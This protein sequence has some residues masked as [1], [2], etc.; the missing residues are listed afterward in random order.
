MRPLLPVLQC[1]SILTHKIFGRELKEG[2]QSSISNFK[3]EY[4]KMQ[5]ALKEIAIEQIMTEDLAS[6]AT[7]D[8]EIGHS[9]QHVMEITKPTPKIHFLLNRLKNT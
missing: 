2:W 6:M 1:D 8:K 7:I 4:H 3:D 5:Q 9:L